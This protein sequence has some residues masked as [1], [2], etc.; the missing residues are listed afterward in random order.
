MTH[1]EWAENNPIDAGIGLAEE[2]IRDIMREASTTR[3]RAAKIAISGLHLWSPGFI[4][5]DAWTHILDAARQ[6]LELS[7]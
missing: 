1:T 4:G 7:L 2:A 6:H 5:A 3:S